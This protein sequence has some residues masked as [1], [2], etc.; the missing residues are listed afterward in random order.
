MEDKDLRSKILSK[1]DIVEFIGQYVE[2]KKSGSSYKGYSPFNEENTP[3][4]SVKPSMQIYNDFSSGSKGDAIKFYADYF[5]ISYGEAM[6]ELANKLGITVD[7]KNK[8]PKKEKLLNLAKQVHQHFKNELENNEYAKN[9]LLNRGYSLEDIQ[10][11]ELGYANSNFTNLKETFSDIQSLKEIGVI[12]DSE[13]DFFNNRIIIP[14]Y[15]I[16]GNVI[17]FGGRKIFETDNGPKYLNSQETYLFSK[18]REL[19]GVKNYIKYIKQEEAAILVEGYFDVLSTVKSGLYSTI[20]TLGT[21]LSSNQAKI[22]SKYAKSIIIAYDND[23]AGKKATINAIFKLVPYNFEIKCFVNNKNDVKDPD[24][25]IK[26]YG[27]Q[28]YFNN[29]KESQT[30]IDYLFDT[31]LESRELNLHTKNSL[32]EKFKP[33]FELINSPIFYSEYIK[34][35][36]KKIELDEDVLK[37]Y[38]PYNKKSVNQVE[39]I[40]QVK[41]EKSSKNNSKLSNIINTIFQYI[42]AF[43]EDVETFSMVNFEDEEKKQVVNKILNKEDISQ[44]I[45]MLKSEEYIL[46]EHEKNK[47]KIDLLKG[48]ILESYTKIYNKIPKKNSEIMLFRIDIIKKIKELKDINKLKQMYEDLIEK[49][50]ILDGENK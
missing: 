36:S 46:S 40:N 48:L 44:D 50:G 11:Y 8:D 25:Y 37:A 43:P 39:K 41:K 18:S 20:A 13:Y 49:G 34:S 6:I 33:F 32:L 14:I 28:E 3:S 29:L 47:L 21:A 1:I 9:Y 19:F 24:E 35:L 4:F 38:F 22:L 17:A 45:F 5:K 31:Y 27:I 7:R 15:D 2:L 30:V 12:S 10:K 16:Y 26:K 42:L 23:E